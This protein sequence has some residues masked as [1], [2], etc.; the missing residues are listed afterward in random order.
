MSGIDPR[1]V[2]ALVI[3]ESAQIV[4]DPSTFLIAFLLPVLL[5][6]MFGYAINLDNSRTR[7]GLAVED[8]SPAALSLASAYTNSRYFEV[9]T[10]RSVQQLKPAI[11]SGAIRGIVVIPQDFGREVARGRPGT[12]QVVTDGSQP[13]MA[14]F[15]AVYAQ[16]VK[17]TWLGARDPRGAAAAAGGIE[18]RLRM[19]FNPELKSS[20]SLVLGSVAI[21]MAM[22][23]TLLTS[24]IIAR[25][26]ERGTME[27][28]MATPMRM[29]EFLLSKIIPYFML[30]LVSMAICTIVALTVFG[31][32]FRG[33]VFALLAISMCFLVPALGM[34][35]FISA[36]TKNQFVASQ[37]A[38]L[39]GF[40]PTFLLS[41]F[42]Y[43]ISSMPWPIQ[44]VTYLVP[45]RYLIPSLQ[46]VFMAGDIWSVFLPDMAAML[47][48]GAVFF[49]LTIRATRRS[50]DT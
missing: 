11:V 15:I 41:G 4:R 34:G 3:K 22:V 25:E 31:V 38:L 5:L 6:F 48:F 39:T 10:A 33:S 29:A 17:T 35:L 40:L 18:P 32:P 7:I 28:M 50:L 37:V 12:I 23:G 43:E 47:L 46:T 19:W 16:G 45:A 13:N 20:Y 24:L 9:T 1:R 36:S 2:K 42:L 21:V 49:F 14:N 30:G 8:D 27:A 44:L 26:W